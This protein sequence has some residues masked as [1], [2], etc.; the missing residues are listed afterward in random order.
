MHTSQENHL[1]VIKMA[2]KLKHTLDEQEAAHRFADQGVGQLFAEKDALK[3]EVGGL[4]K[5]KADL[6]RER[7][8]LTRTN[9]DQESS[10]LDLL[11][12]LHT[13]QIALYDPNLPH[14]TPLVPDPKF[15]D[16]R[17]D[18]DAIPPKTRVE[19]VN[20]HLRAY[21][22]QLQTQNVALKARLDAREH[23]DQTRLD[24]IEEEDRAREIAALEGRLLQKLPLKREDRE[25]R[26][27][28]PSS[29]GPF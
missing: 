17:L 26:E 28:S 10:I 6:E 9:R 8:T 4:K 18:L 15:T 21:L 29:A 14:L 2:T 3:V 7:A 12:R 25:R 16:L 27:V 11:F 23:D 13:A 22:F 1:V 20:G 5:I 24:A 19:A